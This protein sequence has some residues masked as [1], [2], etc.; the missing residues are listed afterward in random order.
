MITDEMDQY[1][2]VD[3]VA[4]YRDEYRA[5]ITVDERMSIVQKLGELLTAFT[6]EHVGEPRLL[7]C[8]YKDPL[9]HV[10]VKFTSLNELES[11]VED[12]A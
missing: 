8:L 5:T 7:I 9:L 2:D 4:V 1:S 10:D 11:R 12:P 6:G 3:L